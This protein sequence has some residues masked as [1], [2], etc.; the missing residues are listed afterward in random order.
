MSLVSSFINIISLLEFEYD[1]KVMTREELRY[2]KD[3]STLGFLLTWYIQKLEAEPPFTL[4]P[5]VKEDVAAAERRRQLRQLEEEE[6]TKLAAL[7]TSVL[8]AKK[9]DVEDG[10]AILTSSRKKVA[11]VKKS[12]VMKSCIVLECSGNGNSLCSNEDCLPKLHGV[13]Q[14][15]F[16]EL[17]GPDHSKHYTQQLKSHSELKKE[18]DKQQ[19]KELKQKRNDQA[20]ALVLEP[21]SHSKNKKAEAQAFLRNMNSLGLFKSSQAGN[22]TV[23]SKMHMRLII[24]LILQMWRVLRIKLLDLLL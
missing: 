12:V 13:Y 15:Y 9:H 17:H 23:D 1:A 5:S 19:K 21:H 2:Y 24:F 11:V 14:R 7:A 3:R 20:A 18:I 22:Y 6:E 10:L 4:I 8:I 16:C